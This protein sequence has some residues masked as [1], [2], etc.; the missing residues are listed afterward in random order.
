MTVGP[1]G[2][3]YVTYSTCFLCSAT[4]FGVV[5]DAR[6]A[7]PEL[8]TD[9][10]SLRVSLSWIQ[11]QDKWI[12]LCGYHQAY[13]HQLSIRFVTKHTFGELLSWQVVESLCLND[14]SRV[15]L[16]GL[17]QTYLASLISL[18]SPFII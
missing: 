3:L 2:N 7:A 12:P 6:S 11:P 17:R 13:R 9:N 14:T 8:C 1:D 5:R 15:V 16:T 18:P 10:A 4:V